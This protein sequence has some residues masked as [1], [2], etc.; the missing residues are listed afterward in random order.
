MNMCLQGVRSAVKVS[1]LS[2][3]AD[4]CF[5]MTVCQAPLRSTERQGR[6]NKAVSQPIERSSYTINGG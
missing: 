6:H 3:D 1:G 4:T 5:Q 2:D